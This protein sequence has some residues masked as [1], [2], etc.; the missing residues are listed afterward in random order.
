MLAPGAPIPDRTE[1]VA[2]ADAIAVASARRGRSPEGARLATLAAD[3]RMRAYRFDRV[4][5]DAREALELYSAAA[6]AL[7]DAEEGCEIARKRAL[8]QGEIN[9]DPGQIYREV[10]LVGKRY[11]SL[12]RGAGPSACLSSV[13]RQLATLSSFRPSGDALAAL[14]RSA[15]SQRVAMVPP[16]LADADAGAP[17][18]AGI[19]ASALQADAQAGTGAPH[20]RGDVLVAPDLADAQQRA[21]KVTSVERY[22]DQQSARIVLHLSGPATFQAGAL[23]ADPAS[24]A[25]A[26]VFL[27]IAH[28]SAK[29]VSHEFAVGG[30]VQRVRLGSRDGGTRVVL[31]LSGPMH[32]KIFFLP[33][34][35]RI[36]VDVSTQPTSRPDAAQVGTSRVVR[37]VA[38]DPGHGGIDDGATGP[39][40]LHEKEVTLDIAHR[41]APVLSHELKIE[42]LLTRDRDVY[43]P[44]EARTALA[45][46]FHADLF[47]SIHCNASE[48]GQARGVQTFHLDQVRDPEGNSIRLAARENAGRAKGGAVDIDQVNALL[49][50]LNVGDM[51]ARSRHVA[52]LFQ[53]S[54]LVTL[55]PRYPDT[56][57][58]GV[59]SA[60]FFVLV[61]AEMPAVLFETSFISNPDDEARLAK[62]DYRQKLADAIINAIRAYREGR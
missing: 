22:G 62:A 11:A 33:D 27:D 21:V 47:V 45:N 56:K 13:E 6:N 61:G 43:V 53:R 55:A 24:G 17:L 38:L 54:A 25:N 46:A 48:N 9:L 28:A 41:V 59:K 7:G 57:D 12:S 29:G 5:S 23:A 3:L 50:G 31:D 30:A 18:D 26:R 49:S 44:L 1:V 19:D 52:D 37:R 39:T 32:R 36:V 14:E 40:G 20:P 8:A 42:S 15:E 34:P 2:L 51:V 16:A 10:F 58:Q 4:A 35:F 60:G